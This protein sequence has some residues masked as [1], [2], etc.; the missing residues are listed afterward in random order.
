M[1]PT[2]SMEQL[3]YDCRLMNTASSSGIESTRQLRDWLVESD[4]YYDPQAYVLR[5]DVVLNLSEKIFKAPDHFTRSK[6]AVSETVKVLREA[7]NNGEVKIEDR[8]I[9]WFDMIEK[10]VES[11]SQDVTAFTEEMILAN[12]SAKFD[13]KKYDL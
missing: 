12:T 6:I 10:E 8:E 7:F 1:A 4:S 2:I 11:I 5:P 9:V 3:A 13:P